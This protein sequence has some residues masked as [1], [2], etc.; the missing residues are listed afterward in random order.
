MACF[1]INLKDLMA[2]FDCEYVKSH[3]Y[4]GLN[5]IVSVIFTSVIDVLACYNLPEDSNMFMVIA[6][7][8]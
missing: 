4:Q 3:G 8:L 5:L 2:F 7:K 6:C 1:L